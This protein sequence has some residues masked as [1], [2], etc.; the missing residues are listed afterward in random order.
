M[1]NNFNLPHEMRRETVGGLMENRDTTQHH[2]RDFES[3]S[4]SHIKWSRD[5]KDNDLLIFFSFS[6]CIWHWRYSSIAVTKDFSLKVDF[7]LS[8]VSFYTEKISFHC[9]LDTSCMA[10]WYCL[11][12][13]GFTTASKQSETLHSASS[14]LQHS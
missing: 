1:I 14:Y 2:L 12:F 11:T 6:I 4:T 7:L 3:L 9:L 13:K 10:C 8:F 5:E